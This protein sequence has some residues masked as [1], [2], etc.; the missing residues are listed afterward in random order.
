MKILG[1][2]DPHGSNKVKKIP[3]KG[4][5][6]ILITGD[7]GKAD[8]ARRFYFENVE[9]K[10]KGLP[11]LEYSSQESKT[12]YMEIYNSSLNVL[13]H[14]SKHSPTYSILGNVGANMVKDSWVKKDEKK[15]GIKLPS[16]NK[17]L[18]GLKNFHLVK[19][20]L[21]RI[22]SLRVGFLEFFTDTNW[23]RDF[24][25]FDYRNELRDAKKQTDKAKKIL[26]NFGKV[27][28]LVCHQPPYRVLDKMMNRK[29][30]KSWYGKHAGSK[31]ILNYIK[32]YQPKYVFC[33]HMHESAGMKKIGKTEVYNLG[34][35]NYKI[36]EI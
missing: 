1:V 31:V 8:F 13:R 5:D 3:L 17:A 10:K 29:G 20:R 2:G 22:N 32:R 19:N 12:T 36:I 28:I 4:V 18:S 9:R 30:P 21:R 24:K 27:D 35:A 6:L 34:V 11:E 23:V 7:I 16:F 33:G 15:H 25:P 26:K 14:F